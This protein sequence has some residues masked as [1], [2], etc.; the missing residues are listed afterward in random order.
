MFS[1]SDLTLGWVETDPP[2]AIAAVDA[3]P[4]A[5][6]ASAPASDWCS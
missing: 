6:I 2:P 5:A 1:C 3:P 4:A